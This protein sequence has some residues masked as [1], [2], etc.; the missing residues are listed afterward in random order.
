MNTEPAFFFL[1]DKMFMSDLKELTRCS[2][3]MVSMHH[4]DA[5]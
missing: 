1:F 3:G 5:L 4:I 2:Y